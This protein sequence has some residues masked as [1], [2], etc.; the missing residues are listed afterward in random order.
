M[1]LTYDPYEDAKHLGIFKSIAG[2][3]FQH[4]NAGEIVGRILKSRALYEERQKTKSKKGA[5]E[6]VVK[7]K[8]E[9]RMKAK[10]SESF[11]A[12]E[13]MYGV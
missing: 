12:V 6:E 9:E 3:V 7:R 11:R 10:R 4:I 8:Q 13:K 2:H 5:G 1:P